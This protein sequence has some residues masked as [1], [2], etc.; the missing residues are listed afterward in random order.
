[1][2]KYYVQEIGPDNS[3]GIYY[4]SNR[5]EKT[6]DFKLMS[7]VHTTEHYAVEALAN[8]VA[9]KK[10]AILLGTCTVTVGREIDR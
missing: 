3:I 6:D 4:S 8:F 2:Y 5:H 1:M 7:S 9:V 10:Q